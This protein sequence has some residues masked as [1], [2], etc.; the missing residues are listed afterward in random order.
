MDNRNSLQSKLQG[1]QE[2]LGSLLDDLKE[3]QPVS[4]VST[5]FNDE[6]LKKMEERYMV[7]MQASESFLVQQMEENMLA[8]AVMI[9]VFILTS[10]YLFYILLENSLRLR[11]CKCP[12]EGWDVV[13]NASKLTLAREAAA[14][15]VANAPPVCHTEVSV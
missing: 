15:A 12:V 5:R 9:T 8:S 10:L 14:Q 3:N 11:R 4:N 1:L 7:R 2:A 13:V 6:K